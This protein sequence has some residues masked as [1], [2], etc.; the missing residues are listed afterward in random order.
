MNKQ[1]MEKQ[2]SLIPESLTEFREALFSWALLPSLN[3][4]LRRWHTNKN[5]RYNNNNNKTQQK[6]KG[7]QTFTLI[8]WHRTRLRRARVE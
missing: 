1:L 7:E 2:I 8:E 3:I 4:A 6:S 5:V